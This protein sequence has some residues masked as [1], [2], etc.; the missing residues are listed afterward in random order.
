MNRLLDVLAFVA[1]VVAITALA[2]AHQ[3]LPL[4]RQS[5]R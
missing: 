4:G 3:L 1:V 2:L 5:P